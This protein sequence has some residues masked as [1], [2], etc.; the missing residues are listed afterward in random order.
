MMNF[1][2]TSI[3]STCETDGS[4]IGGKLIISVICVLSLASGQEFH[5]G[6]SLLGLQ[7]HS[8][9]DSRLTPESQ[10]HALLLV[11]GGVSN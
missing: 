9:L 1:F 5:L 2:S 7:S 10:L 4:S 8:Y 3:I 11:F 6:Y